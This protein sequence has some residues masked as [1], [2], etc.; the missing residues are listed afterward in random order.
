M[1]FKRPLPPFNHF[2]ND[3]DRS[4]PGSQGVCANEGCWRQYTLS[5][6]EDD[7]EAAILLLSVLHMDLEVLDLPSADSPEKLAFVA[8]KY[9]CAHLLKFH[10]LAWIS[11]WLE[12]HDCE[13]VG[14]ELPRV[15][16]F[17]YVVDVPALFAKMSWKVITE[18][19]GPIIDRDGIVGLYPVGHPLLRDD[20]LGRF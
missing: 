19:C 15:L 2:P 8:D 14:P 20:V 7:T 5:L 3:A 10:A 1:P 16:V 6:F 17:T 11:G 13:L 9:R 4:L 18:N 12:K